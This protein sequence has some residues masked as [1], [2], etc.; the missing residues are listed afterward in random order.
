MYKNPFF[1]L[2]LSL[3][4]RSFAEEKL[5]FLLSQFF[6]G[7]G[8]QHYLWFENKLSKPFF[9]SNSKFHQ[10]FTNSIFEDIIL[11]KKLK[12]TLLEQESCSK[13]PYTK[14]C[15]HN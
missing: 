2:L 13:H 8:C 10:H 11:P 4:I 12:H 14:R 5:L 7:D 1:F 15:F 6:S 9:V 3:L